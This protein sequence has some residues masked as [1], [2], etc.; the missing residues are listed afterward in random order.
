[1]ST[2]AIYNIHLEVGRLLHIY[3]ACL[4]LSLVNLCG[5]PYESLV[6]LLKPRSCTHASPHMH[7][8]QTRSNCNHF[9]SISINHVLLLN[10]ERTQKY[11]YKPIGQ[12]CINALSSC[13]YLCDHLLYSKDTCG[14]AKI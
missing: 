9:H 8:S 3:A 2:K 4:A 14:H 11:M 13:Y 7:Y 10:W 6:M 1:M 5:I 12:P